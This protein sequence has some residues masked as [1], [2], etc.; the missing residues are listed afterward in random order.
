MNKKLFIFTLK[1]C[2]QCKKII[3]NLKKENIDYIELEINEFE[4]IWNDIVLTTKQDLVPVIF[5][6]N[7]EDGNGKIYVPITDYNDENELMD[8]IH[9]NMKNN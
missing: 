2:P 6:Q 1:G 7:D 3:N 4:D 8:I 5:I 9:K